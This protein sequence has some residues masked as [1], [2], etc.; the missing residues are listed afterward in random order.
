PPNYERAEYSE[1]VI[2]LR[3]V[4]AT[5]FTLDVNGFKVINEPTAMAPDDFYDEEKLKTVYHPEVERLIK[6]HTGATRTLVFD[7][8]VRSP[9][10]NIPPGDAIH[11]DYTRKSGY[12][13]ARDHLSPEEADRLTKGRFV[14]INLWRPIRTVVSYPLCLADATTAPYEDL[15][16]QD[17]VYP[18]RVGETGVFA[19]KPGRKFYYTSNQRIDEAYVLKTFESDPVQYRVRGGRV[20]MYPKFAPHGA[21]RDPQAPEDAPPRESLEVRVLVFFEDDAANGV[22]L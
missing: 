13:R 4:D 1:P 16:T 15:I 10:T 17:L 8:I 3:S 6:K 7:T 11:S 2:D 5:E 9:R 20:L 14:I 19:H 18:H 21:F 12:A 22:K